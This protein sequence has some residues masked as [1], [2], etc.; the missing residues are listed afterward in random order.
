MKQNGV[1]WNGI[2]YPSKVANV[3]RFH[4]R[5]TQKKAR[6]YLRE[7]LCVWLCVLERECIC[8]CVS[9]WVW[10]R[11]RER[12]IVCVCVCEC[13]WEREKERANTL[14][15]ILVEK[16]LNFSRGKPEVKATSLLFGWNIKFNF[17]RSLS[18]RAR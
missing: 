17:Q 6:V 4:R 10:V 12:E 1:K 9:V 8:K 14:L 2:A 16:K 18:F 15:F 3:L 11:E 5:S 13:E 7:R